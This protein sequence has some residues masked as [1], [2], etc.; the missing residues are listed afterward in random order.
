MLC[1]VRSVD[2]E[3]DPEIA[4]LLREGR[5]AAARAPSGRQLRAELAVGGSFALAALALLVLAPDGAKWSV[6]PLV[7]LLLAYAVAANVRFELGQGETDAT[8]LVLVPMLFLLPA[9]AVPLV[10]VVGYALGRLPDIRAR[11]EHP[12]DLVFAFAGSWHAIGPALVLVVCTDP[13]GPRWE[14]GPWYLV[15]LA[16]LLLLDTASGLARET[17]GRGVRPDLQLRLLLRVWGLDAALAPVGLLAAFASTRGTY[18][19]LLL[20]PLAVVL[21]GLARERETRLGHALAL[22]EAR[23]ALLES[24]LAAS[25]GRE[26]ALAAVSHGLQTPL[27]SVVGLARLLDERGDSLTAERRI[28]AVRQ[29]HREALAL[30][31]RV[32]QILD[33]PRLRAGRPLALRPGRCD[34]R[35]VVGRALEASGAPVGT[36]LSGVAADVLELDAVRLEQVVTA[37]VENAVRHGAAPLTIGAAAGPDGSLRVDVADGGPGVPVERRDGLFDDPG[38]RHGADE[39]AGT[40]IGLYVAAGIAMT[41]GGTLEASFPAS[42]GSRFVLELPPVAAGVRTGPRPAAA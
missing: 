7:V 16:A 39:A 37:V 38:A 29:L 9:E 10:V 12:A 5:E 34:L 13:G 14:D 1:G 6:G 3:L 24:E 27:A 20:A 11:R 42:G 19:F 41:L 15:A 22:A 4:A 40:G 32:R 25:K 33:Y 36:D 8:L 2:P 31:H 35:E 18:G 26:E 23:T 28:L 21:G 17:L 30:R